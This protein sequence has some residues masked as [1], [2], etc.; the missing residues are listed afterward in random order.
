MKVLRL[1]ERVVPRYAFVILPVALAVNILTYYATRLVTTGLHHYNWSL[2]VDSFIPFI[3]VFVIVYVLSYLQWVVGFILIARENRQVCYSVL[4][5]E[6]IAKLICMAVFFIAPTTMQR[7]DVTG[8]DFCS[9]L[10][11][12]LYASD[13]A[14]NL[15]P[16][17]HCLESWICFRGALKINKIGKWYR[18]FSFIFALLVFA[19]VVFI[20][21]HVF[22]D[23]IG[24]VAV[25]ELGLFFSNKTGVYRIFDRRGRGL[26]N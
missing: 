3:P 7:A 17:I 13:P 20:K 11:R 16:S 8:H 26:E 23:I 21:Q 12:L 19:A 1:A 6:I 25:A 22:I 14:D 24:G 5:G 2:P 4:T 10:V 9:A 18:V 15:F